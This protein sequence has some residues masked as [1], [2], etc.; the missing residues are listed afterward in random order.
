MHTPSTSAYL[1]VKYK[2]YNKLWG[3]CFDGFMSQTIEECT[4]MSKINEL[5]SN[6]DFW[7]EMFLSTTLKKGDLNI[8]VLYHQDG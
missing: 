6:K 5:V 4:G 3:K 8:T 1:Q 7:P 2:D